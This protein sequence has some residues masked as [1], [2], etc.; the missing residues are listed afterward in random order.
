MRE[1]V[2]PLWLFAALLGAAATARADDILPGHSQYGE[3]FN[4]G[5]RR[6]AYL[7][8]GTGNVHFPVSSKDPLDKLP[9]TERI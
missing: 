8:G 1:T 5:P 4:R 9:C 7:M 2:S 3:A 6:S